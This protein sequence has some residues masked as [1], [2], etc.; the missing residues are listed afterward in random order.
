MQHWPRCWKI[1]NAESGSNKV[2]RVPLLQE[3]SQGA[4][5]KLIRRGALSHQNYSSIWSLGKKSYQAG[6]ALN[7]WCAYE[8]CQEDQEKHY[9]HS[10]GTTCCYWWI[11]I[12][13][14]SWLPVDYDRQEV[15]P[16]GGESS[17][18][19]PWTSAQPSPLGLGSP[20]MSTGRLLN[21]K[22]KKKMRSKAG[23]MKKS[24]SRT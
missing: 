14:R 20:F 17:A 10:R 16:Y 15:D 2:W 4:V 12:Q 8:Q 23:L 11:S 21:Q 3:T 6:R 22:K 1:Q 9:R 18:Q 24:I 19:T 7:N 13:Q 5:R